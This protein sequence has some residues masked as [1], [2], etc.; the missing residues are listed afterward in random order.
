MR[1][2][3]AKTKEALEA[4]GKD[5]AAYADSL[6]DEAE[7]FLS[8]IVEGP[9]PADDADPDLTGLSDWAAYREFMKVSLKRL[10]PE[11][12]PFYVTR[13]KMEFDVDGKPYKGYGILLGKKAR[14]TVQI[15][16]KQGTLF[17]EG[18]CKRDG[19]TIKVTALKPELVKGAAKTMVKLRLGRKIVPFGPLPTDEDES[20]EDAKN[21]PTGVKR[22]DKL[23]KV[24]RRRAGQAA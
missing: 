2:A 7:G 8:E 12:G 6:L 21:D 11:G 10:P 9:E 4:I 13:K 14:I 24:G 16:K 23:I 17:M 19:K 22:L 20:A 1:R 15:L 18:E 3:T 5:R